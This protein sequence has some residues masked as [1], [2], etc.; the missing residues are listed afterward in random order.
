M[1]AYVK[2]KITYKNPAV[3]YIE[4]H[5]VAYEVNISLN[6]YSQL[7]GLTEA[8]LYTH[9]IVREDAHT[10]FGFFHEDERQLFALLLSVSGV[11]PNTARMVL[12]SLTPEEVRRAILEENEMAF[13]QVKGIGSKTAK[14]II[15]DLKNRMAKGTDTTPAL[16]TQ[17]DNTL[18]EEA[19]SALLALGFT[20]PGV[21]KA[22]SEVLQKQ[23][24]AA[25]VETLVKAS[26]KILS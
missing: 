11:G 15:L 22:I 10:L 7:E 25:S 16:L 5:G 19:L 2:G 21:L 23:P 17:R 14:Q 3:V 8:R 4:C 13:R 24:D 6:T 20:R 9:L 1:I 26:L 18:Q 12:S